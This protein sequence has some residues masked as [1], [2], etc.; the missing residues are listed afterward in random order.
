MLETSAKCANQSER[1]RQQNKRP[2]LRCRP[3]DLLPP[4]GSKDVWNKYLNDAI[5]DEPKSYESPHTRK[6]P[7]ELRQ[8]YR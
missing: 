8:K 4:N 5:A 6:C 1:H 3:I 7:A 2:M